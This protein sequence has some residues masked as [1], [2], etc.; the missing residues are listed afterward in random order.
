MT[1]T[2]SKK[3]IFDY[4][5]EWAENSGEWAK[6]LTKIAVEKESG[7]SETELNDIYSL[8]FKEITFE[9]KNSLPKIPRPIIDLTTSDITLHSLSDIKGVNR[10]AENQ[11][12]SFSKNVTVIYGE[13][14]S[15]KSGYSRILKSLGFS[16]EK[17]TNVLCNVYC[18]G[19][20]CQNAKLIYSKN[21]DSKEFAWDGA[22][23]CSDLQGISVF[24][25][26]CVNISL[27]SK[28]EL[29]VTPIG[30]HL[31]RVVSNELDNLTALHKA[32]IASLKKRIDWLSDLHDGTVVYNFLDTL[33]TKSSKDELN[34]LGT[35]TEENKTRLNDLQEQK[36]NLNKKLIQ[37]EIT[38]FQNQLRE[39]KTIKAGIEGAKTSFTAQDW[40][41]IGEH[42]QEIEA[43]KQKEQKG[44]K[45]IAQERG[46]EFY[47]SAEFA[48][49]IRAADNYIKKLGKDD[50][51]I[52]E[53]EICI[54]CRQKLTEK[55][56]LELLTSYR[57]FF[58][59]P[60][61]TQIRQHTQNFNTLQSKLNSIN[62]EITLHYPSY[63]EDE[64][65]KPVQPDSLINFCNTAK[66]LK[67][68][69]ESKSAEKIKEREFDLNYDGVINALVSKIK[70]IEISLEKKEKSL[71]TIEENEKKLDGKINEL[72]DRKK[73]NDKYPEAKKF[74]EGLQ[75]AALLEDLTRVFNT[76][77]LSRK[78]SQARKDL[79]AKNFNKTFN[80]ELKGLRRSEIKVN[81]N[82]RTDKA[83]SFI[84]QDIGQDY[85]LTDVLSE[86]EQKAIALAEFLTELQLDESKAP[87]VFDDPVT[88]LDHKIIE[89]VARRMVNM[90]RDRQVVIFT[91]SVLLFNSI[92]QKSEL[93][94]FKGIEFKYYET[95][96][97]TEHAGFLHESPTLKEDTFK[98]YKKKINEILNL[99]KEDRQ[100]RENELAIEGYN[101][102]RPAIEVLVEKEMFNEIVKRYRKN[103][104]LMRLETVNGALID[105]HKEKLNDIYERCCEYI[106]PH[107]S[108]DGLSQDPTLSELETDFKEVNTIRGDFV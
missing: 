48:G 92:K 7:L 27:D 93:P 34:N 14:A 102:L 108:P 65:K 104:A 39:L 63:G 37:S 79:I 80:E 96:T 73:L 33:S 85:K 74:L 88:S 40:V 13:N 53:D 91:H 19:D 12:L 84:L 9:D 57:L 47:E 66:N 54:Y 68:L 51:P 81:L 52:D 25:N 46:I 103:V 72:L 23:K 60:T 18:K 76:D 5:W 94:R 35:F 77:P 50:Y 64:E 15:G 69:S 105:K 83:K 82:F 106:E 100:K 49:F 56:A 2:K 86:G 61:Q 75:V 97:D 98:N 45:D 43:L 30:F 95:N 44:L 16:Y 31:F 4:L 29:L 67:K 10:L 20:E 21:G 8:F 11:T 38:S 58:N 59:D 17:E 1:T 6:N 28:R 62:S 107:S 26:N 41:K 87:V 70:A 3:E 101:K 99:P 32:K 24:T 42:L 90:S 22:C 71:S 89:E 36:R 78:T 55:D